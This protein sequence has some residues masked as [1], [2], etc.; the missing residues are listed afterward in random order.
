[1]KNVGPADNAPYATF[2]KKSIY[3]LPSCK[4]HEPRGNT[5]GENFGVLA[6]IP[7]LVD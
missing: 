7:V 6:E 1:L 4:A 5:G 2:A 3:F